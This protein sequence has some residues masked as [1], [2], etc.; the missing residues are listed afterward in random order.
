MYKKKVRA[1]SLIICTVIGNVQAGGEL[2]I[3]RDSAPMTFAQ[4]LLHTKGVQLL[5][6]KVVVPVHLKIAQFKKEGIS[7]RD[8]AV[9]LSA[10]V[11]ACALLKAWSFFK[12]TNLLKG[13][14]RPS[15]EAIRSIPHLI[16]AHQRMVDLVGAGALGVLVGWGICKLFQSQPKPLVVQFQHSLDDKQKEEINRSATIRAFIDARSCDHH[17][18]AMRDVY[19][20]P[21]QEEMSESCAVHALVGHLTVDP[22]PLNAHEDFKKILTPHQKELLSLIVKEYSE[23]NEHLALCDE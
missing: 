16:H 21:D 2:K 19:E 3:N 14:S 13:D 7:K 20:Q 9:G 18:T 17:L 23:N 22:R 5:M 8:V 11:G 10:C 6:Q 15:K 12:L 4:R 1:L